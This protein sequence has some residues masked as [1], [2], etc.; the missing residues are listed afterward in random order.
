MGT[1]GRTDLI[2]V[3]VLKKSLIQ[4][5]FVDSSLDLAGTEP[6]FDARG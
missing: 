5:F 6:E 1:D 2:A 3:P 4:L